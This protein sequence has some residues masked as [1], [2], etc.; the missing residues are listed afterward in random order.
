MF[1]TSIEKILGD[2]SRKI[3][4]LRNLAE[5]HAAEAEYHKE[6]AVVH[7]GNAKAKEYLRD[8]ATRVAEKFE[9]LLK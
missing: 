7:A 1:K 2:I 3:G 4:E 8:R 6:L 5:V 9:E